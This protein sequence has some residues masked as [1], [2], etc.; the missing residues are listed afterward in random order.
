[1]GTQTHRFDQ[2]REIDYMGTFIVLH[3]DNPLGL[4]VG[5]TFEEPLR[6]YDTLDALDCHGGFSWAEY[7]HA[8]AVAN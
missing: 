1:M 8:I 5:Q 6:G 2:P 4:K 3:E 7:S